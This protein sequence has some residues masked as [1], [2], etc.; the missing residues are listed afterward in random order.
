MSLEEDKLKRILEAAIFAAGRPL[1]I[2]QMSKLFEKL[3]DQQQETP[4]SPTT[5][6]IKQA[7]AALMEDYSDRG[8]SL[9][10]VASGWR[11][12]SRQEF[13]PWIQK[14]WEERPARYSRASLETLSLIAYRQ[15]V[16]R[17]EIEEIRGVSVSSSIMKSLLEREWVRVV[18]HRDVPG[19]PALYAT[20]K[21]FLDYFNLKSLDELP[22][23]A[24]IKDL[25]S[26][27]PELD[28]EPKIPLHPDPSTV[29]PG[30][31]IRGGGIQASS[32]DTEST[33]EGGNA[34]GG[35][36][37]IAE[38]EHEKKA[39]ADKSMETIENLQQESGEIILI[40]SQ[41]VH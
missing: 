19:R 40:E 39:S 22:T 35:A 29:I 6:Q 17:A 41:H 16:T 11:F 23:L 3:P 1:T 10:E 27:T 4:P 18:G 38:A 21:I 5:A 13:A 37:S 30:D 2:V 36:D 7:L 32:T 20:T 24:E 28:L 14:L 25:E 9:E 8:V 31:D 34:S 26:L 33:G 15:P 12:Q